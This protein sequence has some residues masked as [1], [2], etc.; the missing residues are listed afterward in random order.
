[1]T[2]VVTLERDETG[3]W[4]AAVPSVPGC[5]THGR[6]IEQALARTREALGLWVDDA[7]DAALEPDIRLTKGERVITRTVAAARDR[8]D[9]ASAVARDTTADAARRLTAAGFSRRDTAIL[10][11]LSHQRIQQLLDGT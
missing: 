8:A 4:I 10:L 11:G 3:A 9:A 2:Y 6:S 7:E 5:H 1:M